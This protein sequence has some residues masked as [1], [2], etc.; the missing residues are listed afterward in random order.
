MTGATSISQHAWWL[1]GRASGVVA[2]ALV[3]LSVGIGLTMSARLMRRPGL[4]RRLTAVHEQAALAGLVAIAVHGLTLLGDP[5]LHP[6]LSGI[7]VPF[8]SAYR[9]FWTGLGIVGGWLAAVL[10]LS[11]Y[12]RRWIGPRLWRRAHR[13]TVAV[14]ALSLLHTIGAG[15]DAGSPWLRWAMIITAVPIVLLLLARVLPRRRRQPAKRPVRARP[16]VR[17]ETA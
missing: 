12:V 13:A 15:T 5:W 1:A 17:G 8:V 2:L 3:T 9:P 4:A 6:G 14:Y 10:G 7:T 16:A 11:F